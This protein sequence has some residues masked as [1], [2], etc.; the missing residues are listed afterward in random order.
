MSIRTGLIGAGNIARAHLPAYRDHDALTLTGVCDA[1]PSATEETASAF[2]VETW[3]DID[4][5]VRE[6][7]LDA[8][9]ITLPHHLH[10]PAARAALE[11]DLHVHV[12]KPFAISMEECRELVALADERDRRLMVG[13][14]Q[15]FD[16]ANR[17]LFRLIE[18]GDLGQ[19]HHV[20]ADGIQNLRDYAAPGHWLYDGKR[21][22]GGGV[23]SVLVHKIDLLRYFVGDAV[24]V[25]GIGK[26]TD[27]AFEAAEDYATV[28]V[29]FEGDVHGQFFS[30]YAAAGIP[31]GEAFWLYGE[32]RV[33]TSLPRTG[34]YGG[35]PAISQPNDKRSFEPVDPATDLA[36]DDPFTNELLH[37]ADC[38]ETGT[39]PLSSGRDNLGTMAV[40][41]AIYESLTRDGAWVDV[42]TIRTGEY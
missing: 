14:M 17:A 22:G 18:R 7:P 16:P 28:L 29:E 25:A 39:A 13:Q 26:T 41:F 40:V 1:D 36:A 23:I 8:V 35:T 4:T 32:E 30:T 15:R 24:R 10:Y 2:E 12:E 37:F 33:A 42:E 20:R 31:Y 21:A 9:D 34:E 6:A 38:I 11:A 27:D 19:L 3:T 5:F